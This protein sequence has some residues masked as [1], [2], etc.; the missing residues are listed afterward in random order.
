MLE[1]SIKGVR[2]RIEKFYALLL[3][4]AINEG[5]CALTSEF[6][7]HCVVKDA[8][9]IR[10]GCGECEKDLSLLMKVYVYVYFLFSFKQFFFFYLFTE[11]EE[12][13]CA[14]YRYLSIN[15]NTDRDMECKDTE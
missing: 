11:W 3:L 8:G 14:N 10:L 13:I 15:E 6:R 1:I 12:I 9:R 7:L 4:D 2:R 5:Y